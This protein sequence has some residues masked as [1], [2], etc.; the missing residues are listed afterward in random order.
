MTTLGQKVVQYLEEAHAT[1]AGLI[2]V[3][4]SQIAMT[5]RGDYRSA[6]ER[7]LRE[8]RDHERRVAARL[9]ELGH[10][11]NPIQA[12]IGLAETVVAQALAICKTP[13]DLLRGNGGAEKVLKNA[14][15]ASATEALEIA[16]Y[17]SL[18]RAATAAADTTTAELAA[19]IRRD[20]ERMLERVLELIPA[21]T[22]AVLGDDGFD[23]TK[24]GAADTARS[25]ARSARSTARTTARRSTAKAKRS[26]GATTP[27]AGYDDQTVE[28]ITKRLERATD[29]K[30]RQVRTYERAHTNRAGVIEATQ[31]ELASA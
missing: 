19:S 18:E 24:T 11:G 26:V 14:R 28:E 9:S 10:G 15:D 2:R 3:F 29:A 12:G 21:L 6:L 25:A 16:T 20:E 31:K 1:E 8:T 7:H 4:Q 30:A 22:D 23:I 27:W 13:L 17:T 5:P